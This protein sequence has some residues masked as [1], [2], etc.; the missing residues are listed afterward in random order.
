MALGI[1]EKEVKAVVWQKKEEKID[2]VDIS[3][4]DV[5]GGWD[6]VIQAADEAIVRASADVP[7]EYIERVIFGIPS[8]WTAGNNKIGEPHLPNLKRLCEQLSL[9]PLGFIVFFEAI[10]NYLKQI[11]GVPPTAIF[12]ELGEKKSRMILTRAGRIE[13]IKSIEPD[14]EK[15][16]A[17]SIEAALKE[18]PNVEV[19]PSR[20]ILYNSQ[21]NLETIKDDLLAHHWPKELPFLHLPKIEI[22]EK[23]TDIKSLVIASGAQ[24]GITNFSP[25]FLSQPTA[26]PITRS[27]LVK[28]EQ[29]HEEAELADESDRPVEENVGFIKDKDVLEM[30]E[31]QE[32]GEEVLIEKETFP[33]KV[34]RKEDLVEEDEGL[35]PRRSFNFIPSF[36]IPAIPLPKFSLPT[37]HFGF[38]TEIRLIFLS[39]AI[40]GLIGGGILGSFYWYFVKAKVVISFEQK[41]LKKETEI[42]V[43]TGG[44]KEDSGQ[45]AG[46][47]VEAEVSGNKKAQTTGQK[48]IG[49]PA[50]GEVI[51][52]NKTENEKKFSK[53][54]VL[55]SGNLAFSLD[56]EVS[57]ASTAAFSTSFSSS[58]AK[59]TAKDIG[60]DGNLPGGVNFAFKDY[61]T[62]S[63]FAKN[64]N[65]FSGGT[66]QKVSTV[67]K[68]DQEKLLS[69]LTKELEEK[70]KADL[71]GKISSDKEIVEPS[72]NSEV[73]KKKFNKEA[74]DEANDVDLDL[75]LNFKSLAYSKDDL[76]KILLKNTQEAANE[77]YEIRNEEIKMEILEVKKVDDQQAVIKVIIEANLS[78]KVDQEKI[79]RDIT[80]KKIAPVKD[81]LKNI[82]GVKDVDIKITPGIIPA[83]LIILPYRPQNIAIEV[84]SN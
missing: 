57:I 53:G 51:I 43:A 13:G 50:K 72:V 23:N 24:M 47:T 15:D 54:T 44:A 63:Y 28:E 40:L 64:E 21:K 26:R 20:I 67:A 32:E 4:I 34:D 38:F 31:Q 69:E 41:S 73:V 70:A 80:G 60:S 75:T 12:L 81:Y 84:S 14:G 35:A 6:E 55:T 19:L 56:E 39:L 10:I 42:I 71:R 8:D 22:L 65:D 30:D 5:S 83:G 78:P 25:D 7:Q 74:G 48:T 29:K 9:K 17:E 33:A 76:K 37:L 66:S 1:K 18:I 59:V 3:S 11:E 52:Y 79:K 16:L 27:Q 36:R 77:N 61:P 2:L 62:S 49:D 82:N 68:G 58:K 45:I 46:E